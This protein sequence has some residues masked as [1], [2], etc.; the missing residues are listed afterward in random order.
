MQPT[1]A[2]RASRQAVRAEAKEAI[3]VLVAQAIQDKGVA[4]ATQVRAVAKTMQRRPAVVQA[5]QGKAVATLA[6]AVVKAMQVVAATQ[7]T[8]ACRLAVLV[9]ERTVLE[10]L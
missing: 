10:P 9:R 3:Q 2:R 1:T 6:K 4:M 8:I 7:G 5:I